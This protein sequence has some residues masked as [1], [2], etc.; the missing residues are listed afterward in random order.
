MK[1]Q[2]HP[3]GRNDVE[4]MRRY[5]NLP[6]EEWRTAQGKFLYLP[7]LT[8]PRVLSAVRHDSQD[9]DKE[10]RCVSRSGYPSAE[11]SRSDRPVEAGFKAMMTGADPSTTNQDRADPSRLADQRIRPSVLAMRTVA[12]SSR[13]VRLTTLSLLARQT[14]V[15]TTGK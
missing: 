3:A 1:Q 14:A 5:K 15:A 4:G 11:R 13:R 10:R 7:M 12:D 2:C 8:L 6:R 9:G